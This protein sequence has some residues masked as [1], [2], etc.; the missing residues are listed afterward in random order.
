MTAAKPWDILYQSFRLWTCESMN[1]NFPASAWNPAGLAF[2][3]T[4]VFQGEKQQQRFIL[5]VTTHRKCTLILYC[6][7][8][9]KLRDL[10]FNLSFRV[11]LYCEWGLI[12]HCKCRLI[13]HCKW[14]PAAIQ[15]DRIVGK[16]LSKASFSYCFLSKAVSQEL[17]LPGALRKFGVHKSG[18]W[19][20]WT[21]DSVHCQWGSAFSIWRVSPTGALCFAVNEVQETKPSCFKKCY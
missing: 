16:D 4:N 18:I 5:H 6:I 11:I 3:I 17:L 14:G 9:Q 7:E 21:P 1:Q 2:G 8:L 12:S 13:S 10:T 20:V 19:W 15:E